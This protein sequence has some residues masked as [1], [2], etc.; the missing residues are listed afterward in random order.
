[1]IGSISDMTTAAVVVSAVDGG[2]TQKKAQEPVV[3][4]SAPAPED[5]LST[6]AVIQSKVNAST[7]ADQ[8][9][10]QNK[11]KDNKEQALDSLNEEFVSEMTKELNELMSKLNCDLEFKYHKEVN[12]MSVKMV[13]KKTNEVIKEY[14]PEEMVEG[15][16]K[17]QE[18]IGAFLDKNA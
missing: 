18:W 1:M 11:E 14:P 8:A 2:S 17:A 3:Q 7:D 5:Q 16:I 15:M 4:Q 13:D 12:V 6:E 10:N 9:D